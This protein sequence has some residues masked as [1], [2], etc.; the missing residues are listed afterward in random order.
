MSPRMAAFTFIK[1]MRKISFSFYRPLTEFELYIWYLLGF[2][3]QR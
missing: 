1:C 3:L 2:N